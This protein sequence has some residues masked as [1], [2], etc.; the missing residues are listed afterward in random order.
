MN[1]WDSKST[2]SPGQ[3]TVKRKVT[4]FSHLIKNLKWE[5]KLMMEKPFLSFKIYRLFLG[6]L[7]LLFWGDVWKSWENNLIF[8][9]TGNWLLKQKL[10]ASNHLLTHNLSPIR[11]LLQGGQFSTFIH[12]TQNSTMLLIWRIWIFIQQL[13]SGHFKVFPV[14]AVCPVSKF[15]FGIF[16][17][18]DTR[19][20]CYSI[21]SKIKVPSRRRQ[22]W[23]LLSVASVWLQPDNHCVINCR[24]KE[25]VGMK[26]GKHCWSWSK[27]Q[28]PLLTWGGPSL[29][30]TCTH[31][32]NTLKSIAELSVIW[33][34]CTFL[35]TWYVLKS[36][37]KIRL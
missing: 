31:T 32:M 23:G 9:L 36:S 2:T 22:F 10:T 7:G 28:E 6:W 15:S 12:S 5:W 30:H 20:C 24:G 3:R 13:T 29:L 14:D 34:H 1:E 21:I 11:I 16:M 37:V 4:I 19:I 35:G 27:R 8:P 26:G 18:F 33:L 17:I 25:R